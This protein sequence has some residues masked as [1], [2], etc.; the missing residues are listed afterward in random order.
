M[1]SLLLDLTNWDLTI[2]ADGDIAVAE[3]PY[4]IAQDVANA[5]KLFLGELWFDTRN[6]VP[7]WETIL[8]KAPPMGLIRA[9]IARAALTVPQVVAA[10]CIIAAFQNRQVTG[11]VRVTDTAGTA[12]NV[13]F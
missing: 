12:L 11:E 4:A 7:Y 1:K 5:V 8:G 10:Q 6:G 13:R 3:N 2:N 9:A